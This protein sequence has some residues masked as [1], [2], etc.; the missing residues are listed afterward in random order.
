MISES[1]NIFLYETISCKTHS[2][3]IWAVCELLETQPLTRKALS[4]QFKQ[5]KTIHM[6]KF[7]LREFRLSTFHQ[8]SKYGFRFLT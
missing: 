6:H 8:K 1:P 2:V 7:E 3:P 5:F 4:E